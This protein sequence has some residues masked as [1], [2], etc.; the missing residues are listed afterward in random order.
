MKL[1]IRKSARS[2]LARSSGR[3]PTECKSLRQKRRLQIGDEAFGLMLIDDVL[4][5]LHQY[6]SASMMV[7]TRRVACG[8]L[9]SGLR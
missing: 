9:G 3:W 4:E 8:S 5:R 2:A 7:R 1:P 6:S